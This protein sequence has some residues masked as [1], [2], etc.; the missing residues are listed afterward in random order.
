MKRDDRFLSSLV[1]SRHLSTHSPTW[2]CSTC[3]VAASIQSASSLTNSSRRSAFTH[4]EKTARGSS[5]S[6]STTM[7]HHKKSAFRGM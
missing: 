2:R 6:Q 4:G 1:H 5:A 3:P 7:V